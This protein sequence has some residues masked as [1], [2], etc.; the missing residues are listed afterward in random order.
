MRILSEMYDI[1]RPGA[2]LAGAT[3]EPSPGMT[4]T[5]MDAM[6]YDFDK[7]P[8]PDHTGQEDANGIAP[9]T[10]TL[11]DTS[12][13]GSESIHSVVDTHS[14]PTSPSASVEDLVS[15][16]PS[17]SP[18]RM[19][20]RLS[21][22][23][24]ARPVPLGLPPARPISNNPSSLLEPPVPDR[25]SRSSENLLSGHSRSGSVSP[26]GALKEE[27]ETSSLDGHTSESLLDPHPLPP[28]PTPSPI[29]PRVDPT[30]VRSLSPINNTPRPRG[31]SAT[32]SQSEPIY[33][34]INVQKGSFTS[35]PLVNTT[36]M[37]GTIFQRRSKY[38][39]TSALP[40]SVP[41]TQV[42]KTGAASSSTSPTLAPPNVKVS[43]TALAPFPSFGPT[44][45]LHGRDRSVSQPGRRP[46]L[47]TNFSAPTSSRSSASTAPVPVPATANSLLPPIRKL[48]YPP[49]PAAQTNGLTVTSPPF[50]ASRP[51]NLLTI[52]SSPLPPPSPP[53]PLRKPYHLMTLLRHTITS[54]T[55]GYI[56]RK[57]HV[58][59][60]VW[61]QGGA[62]L[63]NVPEK[64][65]VI[66]V[67]C[68]ALEELQNG[69]TE[70]CGQGITGIMVF[71]AGGA[72]GKK[73][74]E[75]WMS[76]LDEWANV[77]EGVTGSMGKKLGVGEGFGVKKSSAVSGYISALQVTSDMGTG[78]LVE[79]QSCKVL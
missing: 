59:H 57:L 48:S 17:P 27:L 25:A 33:R 16:E 42:T 53:D 73:E 79:Q 58:P 35:G 75:R 11:T 26:L 3:G 39:N 22:L 10:P 63:A 14:N 2:H 38:P 68:A 69:S 47:T 50:G 5:P 76:K 65:R 67:L 36:T 78:H 44:G 77:C 64:V 45:S 12:Y 46:S 60:E 55:G 21:A 6:K 31:D 4:P 9:D 72:P 24:P 29:T 41:V 66:E 13:D 52:P 34:T 62:K 49:N 20:G 23:P 28:L 8:E 18:P 74:A 70:Y 43:P 71:P 54:R 32:S 37:E 7:P 61:S 56:T 1:H 51:S 15:R 19:L 30:S 40:N